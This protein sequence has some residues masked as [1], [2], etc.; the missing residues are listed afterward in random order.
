MSVKSTYANFSYADLPL[1]T[2]RANE[3][4][5]AAGSKT[6]RCCRNR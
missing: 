2:Y 3:V 5:L 4:V 6:C 1:V